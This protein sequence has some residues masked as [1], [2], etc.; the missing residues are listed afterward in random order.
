MSADAAS[1]RVLIVGCGNIAGGFDDARPADRL[2]V[3]HAG[4]Y[5]AHGGFDLVACV[6]PDSARRSAFA[7]RWKV[8]QKFASMSEVPEDIGVDIVSICSPTAHHR[9]DVAAALSL[10]PKLI[11]CE[12][13]VT[14]T[15][16][17]TEQLVAICEQ[18][19]V[20]LAVNH[21][22]RWAPDVVELAQ[23]LADGRWGQVRS[24][25]ARY[26]KGVLNN[27][28][29]LIDLLLA[30]VGPVIPQWAGTPVSD[31]WPDDPTIS[32]TLTTQSG[33]PVHIAVGHAADYSTFE[34]TLVTERG[35]ISMEDG[36]FN[37]R[38]RQAVDSP[39]FAGYK[40]LDAGT[41]TAGR[42]EQAMLQAVTNL[43]TALRRGEPLASTGHSALEAQ[44]ICHQIRMLAE[45]AA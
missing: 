2:P 8:G 32:A 28:A 20:Y 37:W 34:V 27:G 33:I 41:T 25:S 29:H 45:R 44:R 36:G 4:A 30:L 13:P 43:E 21:T 24:L 18:S 23:Q 10:R 31:F 9:D 42:Y 19:E 1:L 35:V 3:T 11:F 39:H 26:N 17:E 7:A 15:V 12:K 40:A 14:P 22:R 38:V 6:D 5:I 16:E